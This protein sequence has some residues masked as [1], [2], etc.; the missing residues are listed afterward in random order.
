MKYMTKI[1][2][3]LNDKDYM[4]FSQPVSEKMLKAYENRPEG[5]ILSSKDTERIIAN[6]TKKK[7][8][9]PEMVI[10]ICTCD[11]DLLCKHR[12]KYLKEALNGR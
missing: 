9:H 11:D 10:G 2:W 12:K 1:D 3:I 6:H 8:K 4:L 7:L 5:K